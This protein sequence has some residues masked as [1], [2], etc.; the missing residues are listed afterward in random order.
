[1]HWYPHETDTS[2]DLID[3]FKKNP[4][5]DGILAPDVLYYP[6]YRKAISGILKK[7][8]ANSIHTIGIMNVYS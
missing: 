3:V 2:E 8:K 7:Y 4:D 5:I 1:M 6:A